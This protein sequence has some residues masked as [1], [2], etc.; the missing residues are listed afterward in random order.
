MSRSWGCDALSEG[1]SPGNTDP[2]TYD[3]DSRTVERLI[4]TVGLPRVD[5]GPRLL[6]RRPADELRQGAEEWASE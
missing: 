1:S 2:P 5:P 4:A 3:D 6:R